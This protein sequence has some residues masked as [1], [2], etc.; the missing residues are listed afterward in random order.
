MEQ[1]F[2][3]KLEEDIEDAIGEVIASLGL[4][5]LPVIPSRQTMHMMAKAAVTVYEAAVDIHREHSDE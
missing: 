1:R 4:K 5:N 2:V 3:V